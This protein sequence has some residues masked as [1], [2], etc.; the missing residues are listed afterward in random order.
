[1]RRAGR[2][3]WNPSRGRPA[4]GALVPGV[5]EDTG[6]VHLRYAVKGA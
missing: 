4:A 2:T 3:I 1:M 5:T 6:V